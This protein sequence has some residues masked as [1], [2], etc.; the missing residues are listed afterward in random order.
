MKTLLMTLAAGALFAGAA[1]AQTTEYYVVQD[2][3]T[4][5]CSVVNVRP[6]SATQTVVHENDA[7]KIVYKT[8]EDA[9]AGMKKIKVCM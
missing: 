5:K 7:N 6:T 2:T 3:A 8:M 4:K 1:V 9:N